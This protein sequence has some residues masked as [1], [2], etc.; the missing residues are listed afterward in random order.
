MN[1]AARGLAPLAP[2]PGPAADAG[3]VEGEAAN[4]IEMTRL[5]C[6]PGGSVSSGVR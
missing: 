4:L 5:P 2:G 6:G 3:E 1:V